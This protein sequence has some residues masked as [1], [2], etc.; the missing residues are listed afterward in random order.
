MEWS[1]GNHGLLSG[2]R[3]YLVDAM[4]D[5]IYY[6]IYY[7]SVF[8]QFLNVIEF[9]KITNYTTIIFILRS[10]FLIRNL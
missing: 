9:Y 5:T 7:H 4:N 2:I 6:V 3:I 8:I 10:H 1:T